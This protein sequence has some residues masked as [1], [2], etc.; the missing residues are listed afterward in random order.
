[1]CKSKY[2]YTL[3]FAADTDTVAAEDTLIRVTH[4][5]RR[6]EVQRTL[7]P[8][9]GITYIRHTVTMCQGLQITVAALDT[10]GT[11]SA[12]GCQKQLEDQLPIF[13]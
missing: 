11:V 3:Q 12:M 8:V 5:G 4:D 2:T 10:G 6:A 7:F 1:M 13:N 9:I